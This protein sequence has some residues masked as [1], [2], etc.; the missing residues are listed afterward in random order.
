MKIQCV[1][2]VEVKKLPAKKTTEN[3]IKKALQG[4]ISK[5]EQLS[6]IEVASDKYYYTAE[7][8]FD[9][10]SKMMVIKEMCNFVKARRMLDLGY[11]NDIWTK[12]LLEMGGTVD[13][14]EAASEHVERARRDFRHE[15]RVKVFQ[16]LFE[17]YKPTEPYDTIL[18]SG[19]IKHVPN[20]VDFLRTAKAWLK[21]DGVVVAGTPNSRSF[22]RRLGA[23]MGLELV[24]DAHNERD[25]EVFNVH[26]YDRFRWR[27]IFLQAGYEVQ[28]IKGVFLKILSTEQMIY[29]GRKYDIVKIMEGLREMGE[30]LE[31]YA[32][33]LLLVARL[34][35]T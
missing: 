23:Y 2:T 32:W 33:Y 35:Q 26:L 19:V 29:L 15:P 10:I 31:D 25:K 24:P 14:I 4:A 18:M 16:T 9:D 21:P 27:A 28:K 20:D 5:Q 34:P 3:Y 11:I 13:I 17:D 1:L 7:Q 30:E 6:A 12:T 22:H 8:E